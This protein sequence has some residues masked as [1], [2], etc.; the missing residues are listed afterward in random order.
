MS[1]HPGIESCVPS[2]MKRCYAAFFAR[3]ASYCF[4]VYD[5]CGRDVKYAIEPRQQNIWR[6]VRGRVAYL[7]ERVHLRDLVLEN[8][9][10]CVMAC[11][12]GPPL[13]Q[14][15]YHYCI[16]ASRVSSCPRMPADVRS[17]PRSPRSE[18]RAR[19]TD[20][21]ND[22]DGVVLAAAIGR[23]DDLQVRHWDRVAD[24]G[25]ELCGGDHLVEVWEEP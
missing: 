12:S 23:V 10:D 19:D 15:M 16:D 4:G 14:L 20:L 8:F 11:V 18:E 9:V 24:G 17:V 6:R 3:Y 22:Y 1:G 21:A 7:A 13:L 2:S 5:F 25:L